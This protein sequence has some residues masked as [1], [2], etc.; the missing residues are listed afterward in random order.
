MLANLCPEEITVT[1]SGAAGL[2]R[3]ARARRLDETN[4]ERACRSP[5]TYRAERGDAVE[6]RGGALEIHL[7]PYA[8]ARIDW[9]E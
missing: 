3:R 5:D 6:P 9:E 1:V 2:G 4:V 7:L 8:I